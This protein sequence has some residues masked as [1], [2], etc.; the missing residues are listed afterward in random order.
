VNAQALPATT[1]RHVTL[2]VTGI[3][4]VEPL[5]ECVVVRKR[6]PR[7]TAE[8]ISPRWARL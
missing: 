7:T 6:A 3:A 5:G 8:Q 1:A 4:V 2:V